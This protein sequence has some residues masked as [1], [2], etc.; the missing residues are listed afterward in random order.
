MP[1][2]PS[3]PVFTVG[4]SNSSDT[5]V[6]QNGVYSYQGTISG[7]AS[8]PFVITCSVDPSI[9]N[10]ISYYPVKVNEE[11]R[12]FEIDYETGIGTCSLTGANV[13]DISEG[14]TVEFTPYYN[15]EAVA[16]YR[17]EYTYS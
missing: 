6:T 9:V 17:V 12:S 10:D 15:G 14:L 7:I 11:F 3:E 8:D 5:I 13:P 1:P 16:D 2:T 4:C